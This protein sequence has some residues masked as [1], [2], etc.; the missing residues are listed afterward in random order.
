MAQ[1]FYLG[2]NMA[3]TVSAGAYTAGVIDFLVEAMD[4][5]YTERKHQVQQFGTSY[6]LWTIPPHELE[7]DVMAG[8]S[9][10]GITAALAAAAL[11]QEFE[12]RPSLFASS[13]DH[14]HR[15]DEEIIPSARPAR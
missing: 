9:G 15:L 3:G 2:L 1:P 4:A 5:W 7:L 14:S 10:G 12:T 6:D 13:S 8:A 11:N